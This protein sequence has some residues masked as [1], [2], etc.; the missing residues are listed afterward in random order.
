MRNILTQRHKGTKGEQERAPLAPVPAGFKIVIFGT[1]RRG[2][3]VWCTDAEGYTPVDA[4]NAY[5][6]DYI[7]VI[8]PNR[9]IR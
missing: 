6:D 1:T 5:V 4:V 8:R 9:A 2:D 3:L 7:R